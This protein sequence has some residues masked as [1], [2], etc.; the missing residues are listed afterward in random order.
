L[1][2]ESVQDGAEEDQDVIPNG[3][4]SSLHTFSMSLK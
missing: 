3:I 4:V 1:E 2:A